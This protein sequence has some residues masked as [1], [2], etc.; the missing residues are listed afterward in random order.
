MKIIF[1]I[2]E[3]I[4]QVYNKI[5]AFVIPVLKLFVA[6]IVFNTINSRLGYFAKIDS[7]AIELIAALLCSFLPTGVMVILAAAFILLHTYSLSLIAAVLCLMLFLVLY[8]LLLR[9]SP[10]ESIVAVLVP[11]LL[12]WKMPCVL[13][14]VLGVVSNPGAAVAAAVGVIAYCFLKVITSNAVAIGT[15][16]LGDAA[17]Q[18]KLIV[19][20]FLAN[21]GMIVL[22]VAFA[23][24]I[25]AVY[26]LRRLPVKRNW[27]IAIGAGAIIEIV[28]L[29]VGDIIIDTGLSFVSIIL[30]TVL[31]V[32]IAFG[33]K[34]FKFCVDFGRTE[35]V[36]FEDDDYY[37]YVKAVPK[38]NL[39]IATPKTKNINRQKFG[40]GRFVT[41]NT[42][43]SYNEGVYDDGIDVDGYEEEYY[44][45]EFVEDGAAEG[46]YA[47]GGEYA[48]DGEF[49][50]S[51]EYYEG[52]AEVADEDSLPDELEELF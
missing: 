33:I 34:F 30:T 47:E 23:V 38:I 44:E 7:V 31:S 48:E 36:Q 15:M 12:F 28:V 11:V 49:Y 32:A 9:F 52:E 41:G 14:I 4:I 29:I 18:L 40:R 25:I 22:I 50:E 17:E 6:F 37:Y 45:E 39:G 21:K 46:E 20:S 1:E 26:F 24:T 43:D 42:D 51:D 3:K 10:K 35:R 8:L 13:P 2:R 16:E 5:D 19:D 27:E